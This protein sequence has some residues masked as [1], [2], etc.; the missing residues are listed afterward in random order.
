MTFYLR[1]VKSQ[2]NANYLKENEKER[3]WAGETAL[4]SA[5]KKGRIA[6]LIGMAVPVL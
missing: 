6:L 1:K 4:M 2:D 3:G 5:K